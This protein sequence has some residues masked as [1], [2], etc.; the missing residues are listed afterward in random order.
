MFE[1]NITKDSYKMLCLIYEEFLHR[2]D[3]M[4]KQE[5]ALFDCLPDIVFEHINKQDCYSC[6]NE[7]KDNDLIKLYVDDSFLLNNSAIVYMENRFK[8]GISEVINFISSTTS[9]FPR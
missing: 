7:L 1:K 6:L 2:R 8:K 5:A 3:T 9:I 4:S